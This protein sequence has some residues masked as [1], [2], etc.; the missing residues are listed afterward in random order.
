MIGHIDNPQYAHDGIEQLKINGIKYKGSGAGPFMIRFLSSIK[1][2]RA[3]LNDTVSVKA[4]DDAIKAIND[5][6]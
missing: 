6:K 3:K 2:Q 5:A 4:A 1:E